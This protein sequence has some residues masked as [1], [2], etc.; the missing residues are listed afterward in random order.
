VV[1]SAVGAPDDTTSA[2]FDLL[3]RLGGAR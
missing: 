1:L 2:G 3:R